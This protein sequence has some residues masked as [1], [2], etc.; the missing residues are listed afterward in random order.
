[1]KKL[2]LAVTIVVILFS[3]C[4]WFNKKA[5]TSNTVPENTSTLTDVTPSEVVL[6]TNEKYGF[7]ILTPRSCSEKIEV[8]E[9]L[10]ESAYAGKKIPQFTLNY[11]GNTF[12]DY[13]IEPEAEYEK[14]ERPAGWQSN[15]L[16]R[17]K[18]NYLLTGYIGFTLPEEMPAECGSTY[19]VLFT[20]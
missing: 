19:P 11:K 3:G 10:V 15:A 14:L 17:L 18:N 6:Y 1:M 12:N 5:N 7:Q 13:A 16:L 4:S 9:S 2:A 8:K 20:K